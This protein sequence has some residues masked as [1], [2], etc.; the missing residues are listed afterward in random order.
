VFLKHKLRYDDA[1]D[2]VGI[3]GVGGTWGALAT[4]IFADAAVG[5]ADGLLHGNAYQ[6]WVQF[7]SVVATW[8]FCYVASWL[9][10]KAVDAVMGLRVSGEA[11]LAGLDVSEHNETAYQM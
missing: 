4:G 1:L 5:G 7:V 6:L 10:F 9:L 8:L 3:H 11:E 2:V